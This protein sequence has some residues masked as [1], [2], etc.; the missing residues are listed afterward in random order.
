MDLK[1]TSRARRDLVRLHDFLD[2]VHPQAAAKV[3]R[4]LAAAPQRLLEH[5][6]LGQRL[7]A[8]LVR[9][10][11]ANVDAFAVFCLKLAEQNSRDWLKVMQAPGNFEW[12]LSEMRGKDLSSMI[13]RLVFSRDVGC[14]K[15]GLFL[16]DELELDCLA[17]EILNQVGE[18][19]LQLAFYELQRTLI[20][21]NA[22]ARCLISLVPCVQRANP[23]FQQEFFAEL[24][25]QAK[26]FA[27]ACHEEF[28]RR[29]HDVSLL[30]KA[31]DEE[32][33]YFEA[34]RQAQGSSLACMEVPGY[35]NAA[36]L[37]RRRFSNEVSKGAEELSIFMRLFKKT[38]LLYGK[39]W[40]S[41]DGGKLTATSELQ[42]FSSS[43]EV[44]RL[45]QIDPEGM[46]LRRLNASVRLAQINNSGEDKK[47]EE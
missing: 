11:A 39:G 27:G 30:K 38:Q 12:L 16:F 1:W 26:N 14:R 31:L 6:R 25:L 9:R 13:G 47:V 43:V 5:R 37:H 29:A 45:E 23:S 15:L 42:E 24:V 19:E 10:L 3:I 28:E 22:L 2:E 40:S 35:R 44:P 34:L 20:H 18:E 7:E 32:T 36:R 41:F 33:R 8:F 21:G 4:S 17:V 46:A